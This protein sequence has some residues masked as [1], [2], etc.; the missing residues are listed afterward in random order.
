MRENVLFVNGLHGKER[1][2]GTMPDQEDL[3][4]GGCE[5]SSKF[6]G[7]GLGSSS[8]HLAGTSFTKHANHF[9]V[10]HRDLV[11]ISPLPAAISLLGRL[12]F[13]C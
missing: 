11:G 2:G 10:I 5:V 3:R 12:F 1:G 4:D 8:T 9:K 6:R 13:H 7:F